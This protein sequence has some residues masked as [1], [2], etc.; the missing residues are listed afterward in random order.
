[1][2]ESSAGAKA[3][4]NKDRHP[5]LVEGPLTIPASLPPSPS[6][7]LLALAQEQKENIFIWLREGSDHDA[8]NLR[9]QDAGL[10][11]ATEREINSF[12]TEYAHER[13]TRRID[14]A[15]EEADALIALVRRSP[16]QIPEAVLAALGQEAFR[17]IA[18]GKVESADLARYTSLF[19]RAREQ[20]RAERALDIQSERLL[21]AR[22]NATEKALDAFARELPQNPSALAA[23]QNLKNQLL[24]QT[25]HLEEVA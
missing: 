4:L 14:R 13:W 5:E 19:L 16:G 18:S 6:N 11:F 10:P 22:R 25:D 20:D 9:L 23:F 3:P 7:P 8:I 17:Q 2:N 21:L 12:F 24:D 1:M 15:A